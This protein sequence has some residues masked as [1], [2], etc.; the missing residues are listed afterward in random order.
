MIDK[1][2][3]EELAKR[4]K[5]LESKIGAC[6]KSKDELT[7]LTQ[8]FRK[9]IEPTSHQILS[10]TPPYGNLTELNTCRLILD[11]VGEDIL[12]DIA[13]DYLD[14]LATSG[15]ICEA[16]GD[17]ALCVLASGWCRLLDETSRN[18]CNIDDNREALRSGKWLCRESCW[19][20]ASKVAMQTG[21]PVDIE[22]R[23]GIR[24]YTVPVW[25][26]GEIVGAI[27]FSYGDPPR[28][29]EKLQ[30]IAERYQLSLD[31]LQQQAENYESHPAFLIDIAK[32]HLSLSARLLGQII[33]RR[34][35]EWTARHATA[36]LENIFNNSIPLCIT[37]TDYE[38]IQ[39]NDAYY[40]IF[41]KAKRCS[42][43]HLCY[44]SRPGL[45][46][47]T[48]KCPLGQI[49]QGKEEVTV[50]TSKIDGSKE[51]VFIAT[52]RPFRNAD[53]E[54]VGIVQSFQEITKRYQAQKA[55]QESEERF[56][57]LSEATFEAVVI[58]DQGVI[59]D[60]NQSFATMFGYELTEIIGKN[61]LELAAPESRDLVR[62][63]VQAGI[64]T[65][66]EADG[67]RKDG[68]RFSAELHGKAIPYQGRMVR[69]AALLDI[70]DRKQAEE[71]L[72]KAHD[73]LEKRVEERTV[74]LI[75]A[76]RQ[77]GQE[78]QERKLASKA[79]II[80]EA[81][82]KRKKV[83]LEETNTALKVLLRESGEA[84]DELEK[85]VSSNIKELVLPYID[86]LGVVLANEGHKF[87]V[88]II[89]SNL[90]SITSP[91]TEKLSAKY[92]TLTPRE[93]QIADLIRQGQMNKEIARLLKVSPSAVDFH[94][95]NIRKKLNLKGKKA[96]LRSHL[97][98]FVG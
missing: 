29:P 18:L 32:K 35:A 10:C 24:I 61:V 40:S 16:N 89:K 19:H 69:V 17:Y 33:E 66:Y 26:G 5:V 4:V 54:L 22:C 30:H 23:G 8:L 77:L 59:L 45:S 36:N 43:R 1:P 74:E 85:K 79:L 80:S 83:S 7:R 67:L 31:E 56:R 25:A 88:D 52:A 50:T 73:Q 84:K 87:Y 75:A 11:T 34:Q 13:R 91:F 78:I 55:L 39:A 15:A 97:L 47:H 81:D 60:A 9:S 94:R 96:N 41:G 76:N 53:E 48:E 27:N 58:H 63:N 28:D 86:E 90:E 6:W 57:R 38:I 95:R 70:S 93:I 82:L 3:Y 68:S 37:S 46:C 14:L 72:Q 51:R 92:F 44:E 12:G 65:P 71:Q 42:A 62:H 98:S 2:T 20:D 21:R 64:E 49:L